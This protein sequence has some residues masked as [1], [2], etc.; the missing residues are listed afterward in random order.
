MIA[1]YFK[2]IEKTIEA[3]DFIIEDH[4]L[5]TNA[6]AHDKGTIEGELYFNDATTLDFMEAVNTAKNQKERYKYHYM[7]AD[8]NLVFRY[9]NAPHHRELKTFPHH[10]HTE[11]SV[12]ESSE[13]N[14][15][16]VLSEIEK[17]IVSG[18][19]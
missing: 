9:D 5:T 11:S 7:D 18:G 12:I 8:K 4:S 6:L 19:A 13:P 17:R 15:N 14:L 16:S 10:K 3:F 1:K 2:N